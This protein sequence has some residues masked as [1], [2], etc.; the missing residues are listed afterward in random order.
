VRFGQYLNQLTRWIWLGAIL[1]GLLAPVCNIRAAATDERDLSAAGQ[2]AGRTV[3]AVRVVGNTQVSTSAILQ[4]VRTREG[5]KFDP[6]TVIGDYQR[7]YGRMKKFA[8]VEARVQPTETGVIVTFVVTEQKQIKEI[9]FEGNANIKT[10]DLEQ[11]TELKVGE[12]IDTFRI[13][14]AQQ[15]IEKFY[16]E[17]NYPYAHVRWSPTELQDTGVLVFH[18]IEGPLVRIRKVDFIG[19][20]SMGGWTLKNQIKTA[21]YKFIFDPGRYDPE[22]VDEDVA[23][24][25]RYYQDKGFFNVHVGRR[26]SRSVNMQEMQI[27]FVID[28][29]QRFIIDKVIF[30]GNSAVPENVLRQSVKD[31]EGVPYDKE[32][33]DNDLRAMIRVYSKAGGF[34]FQEQAGM[35]PN[36]EYLHIIPQHYFEKEPGKVRLV[37]TISEGKQFRQGRILIKGNTKTQDKVILRELRLRPGQVYDSAAVQD[38]QDR[39]RGLPQFRE[40][41]VSITPVGDDPDSRDLLVEV[42]DG[43]TAQINAGIGINS[44]GGF[45]GQLGFDQQ[46]FDITNWPTSWSELFSDRAFTGAGQDFAV[47]FE[48][49]TQGTNARVSFTEPYLFDQPYAFSA[50][51]Y[52]ETRVRPVYNDDRAGGQIVVGRR[53]NYIYSASVQ[54]GGAD[55]DIKDIA[56]PLIGRAPEILAGAGHHTLTTIGATLDRDTRNNGPIIYQGTDANVTFTTAGAMG[57]TVNYNRITWNY[58]WYQTMTE[59]LLGRR[60]VLEFHTEGGDDMLKAPFFE[61][62]YGGGIGSIRGFEYW[63]VSPRGGILNDAVGGNFYMTGGVEYQFPIAEDFLR[64]VLF[65]DAGDYEPNWQYGVIRTAVGFGFRVNL[66]ILQVPLVLDFGFP[67]VHAS[68]DQEQVLSFSFG[69]RR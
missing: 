37:Y 65:V 68:T 15:S 41:P 1:T 22:Q 43:R 23:S 54:F 19:N 9:R 45:G 32:V 51:G 10:H 26:I 62:F 67:I 56:T 61:R 34:I 48:P 21:Y 66:P 69:I 4:L 53:W 24:L 18:I 17:K 46:N 6:N 8:D 59:D 50:T 49:G 25:T 12:A 52:Y 31:S 55:V 28:E 36:P 60:S 3:E 33:I 30:E 39:L 64:G 63:G 5:E 20:N 40:G 16:R 44:N 38:A 29:G 27:T 14:L 13:N 58:Q 42:T 35:A 47:S 2:F 11:A 7:I 57:G